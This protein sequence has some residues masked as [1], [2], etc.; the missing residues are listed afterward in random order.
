MQQDKLTGPRSPLAA[1]RRRGTC[2]RAAS[3]PRLATGSPTWAPSPWG[4]PATSGGDLSAPSPHHRGMCVGCRRTDVVLGLIGN[5]L[6]PRGL[7]FPPDDW[8]TTSVICGKGTFRT[9]NAVPDSVGQPPPADESLRVL[10]V[11][12]G[13]AWLVVRVET[14]VKGPSETRILDQD[15]PG[16]TP[17]TPGDRPA[18]SRPA[19]PRASGGTGRGM[20]VLHEPPRPAEYTQLSSSSPRPSCIVPG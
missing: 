3:T 6:P 12:A 14:G 16:G 8:G 1:P 15:S 13:L 10:A 18:R 19:T 4:R 2:E 5:V 20:C 17:T 9:G 11:P 7:R